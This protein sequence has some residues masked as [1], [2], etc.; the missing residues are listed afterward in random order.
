MQNVNV[1]AR[2]LTF[3]NSLANVYFHSSQFFIIQN[4]SKSNV[5]VIEIEYKRSVK[6]KER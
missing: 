4:Y 6:V 3:N 5:H 2:C 1:Q